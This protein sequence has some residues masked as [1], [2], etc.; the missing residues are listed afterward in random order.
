M[1]WP[2]RRYEVEY[3]LT[4]EARSKVRDLK[5]EI[6]KLRER[7][8]DLDKMKEAIAKLISHSDL[9]SFYAKNWEK[10]IDKAGTQFIRAALDVARTMAGGEGEI[11]G[12]L[13]GMADLYGGAYT[14][15]PYQF[16]DMAARSSPTMT[17]SSARST[18][19]SPTICRSR[20]GLSTRNIWTYARTS[21]RDQ[22]RE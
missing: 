20:S 18:S 8:L 16:G 3:A 19:S 13:Q 7:L 15:V 1:R 2:R 17:R 5:N 4:E 9:L 11:F 21:R 10:G 12:P 22:A 6:A 14:P